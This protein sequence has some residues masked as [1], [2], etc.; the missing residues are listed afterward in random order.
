[1]VRIRKSVIQNKSTIDQESSRYLQPQNSHMPANMAS[2]HMA[3]SLLALIEWWLANKMSPPPA[4]MGKIYKALIIDG[5]MS[6]V[7]S[8]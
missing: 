5:T 2:Y 4:Q 6:A 1:V 7:A 8:A 3:T